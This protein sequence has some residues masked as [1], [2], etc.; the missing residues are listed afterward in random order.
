MSET[1]KK[2]ILNKRARKLGLE[3]PKQAGPSGVGAIKFLITVTLFRPVHMLL[4]EPIVGFLSLYNAFTFS[5]LFAFFEAFPL[6]FVGVYHFNTW[7]TGLAFI[8][9]GLGVFIGVLSSIACDRILYQK[10][11]RKAMAEGRAAVAPE[12]R[13]YAAMLGSLGIPVGLFWF[14]WTSRAGLHWV[15]PIIASIPFAWGNVS[16]FVSVSTHWNSKIY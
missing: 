1:Y 7:Q 3:P 2:A 12:H 15:V 13:L 10:E 6:V 14:A 16:I 11:H 5:I 9:V 4:F 8:A